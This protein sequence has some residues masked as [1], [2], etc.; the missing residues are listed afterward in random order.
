MNINKDFT[1]LEGKSYRIK[2]VVHNKY[3]VG[4][5]LKSNTDFLTGF[6][7]IELLIVISVFSILII[8]LV[9]IFLT[10]VYI[11]RKISTSQDLRAGTQFILEVMS[12]EMRMMKEIEESQRGNNDS[13]ITFTNNQGE[14]ITYCLSDSG[15]NCDSSGNYLARNNQVMTSSNIEIEE[16]KF[17][18]SDFSFTALP[19]LQPSIIIFIKAKSN[20]PK[21]PSPFSLQTTISPRIYK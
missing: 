4:R 15:G 3:L 6:T 8:A 21:Y 9:N 2:D 7:L 11:Q 20:N 13:D 16:L 19:Y 10:G 1:P 17:K 12:R 18:V 14:K 5:K